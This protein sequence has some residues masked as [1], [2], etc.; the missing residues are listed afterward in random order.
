MVDE[1]LLGGRYRIGEGIAAG[2]MGVVYKARDERLNRTVVVKILREHLAQDPRFVERFRRE[3][4]AVASLSHPN[5]AGIFDYGED[6]GRHFIVMEFAE[7]SD[8]A[9]VIRDRGPL[10]PALAARIAAQICVA[11]DHAHAA[12]IIHRDIKPANV[13]VDDHGRVKVTDFGIAR[14]AGDS[15]LTVTGTML[16]TA[17]Y[18]SPEQASGDKVVPASD[19][20]ALGIVLYEM[21]TGEVPFTADSAVAVAMRHAT[22]EVPA[23][24]SVDPDITEELD[25][26]VARATAKDPAARWSGGRAMAAALAAAVSTAPVVDGDIPDDTLVESTVWPI[27]G[28]R[29]DPERLGRKVLITFAL[30]ALLT[31]V[32]LGMR[33]LASEDDPDDAPQAQPTVTESATPTPEETFTPEPTTVEIPEEILGERDKEVERY[34]RDELGLMPLIEEVRHDARK[35]TVVGSDPEPG[36]TVEVGSQITLY[37]SDG[38]GFPEDDEDDDDDD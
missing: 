17:H 29:W 2:G 34:L 18:L 32:I 6:E 26:V 1:G 15:N 4:R 37:V 5:I 22:D 31:V 3:A 10:E 21:L 19:I 16:G 27:P 14:A 36:S 33:V 12:G 8:L 24:S 9:E 28:D 30:L 11:L 38:K 23:P 20:Y 35:H 7:G 25:S 13:I